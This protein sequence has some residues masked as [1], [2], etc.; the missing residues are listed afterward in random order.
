MP[1]TCG[2]WR[3]WIRPLVATVYVV[4]LLVAVPLCVWELQKLG[5]GEPAAA[6]GEAG[7]A[8]AEGGSPFSRGRR[9]STTRNS[10]SSGR[11]RGWH[12]G[13]WHAGAQSC[14]A[15]TQPEI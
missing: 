7:G 12:P 9:E 10:S 3:R 15:L 14:N 11:F 1:C 8:W 5:V 2:N 4:G 13:K 6:A